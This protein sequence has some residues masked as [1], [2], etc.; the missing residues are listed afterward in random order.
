MTQN[1]TATLNAIKL[2]RARVQ[3]LIKVSRECPELRQDKEFTR[4]L[5]SIVSQVP[6]N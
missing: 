3:F 6:I 1:L 4:K 2:L 5:K